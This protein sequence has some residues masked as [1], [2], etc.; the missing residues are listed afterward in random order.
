MQKKGDF[1]ELMKLI[2]KHKT[3]NWYWFLNNLQELRK[4]I[5]GYPVIK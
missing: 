3:Q 4:E 1:I 5:K 2:H